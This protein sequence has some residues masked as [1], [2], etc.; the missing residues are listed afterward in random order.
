[1]ARQVSCVC[2]RRFHIG[3]SQA[4]VQCRQCGRWWSGTE[5]SPLG[6]VATLLFGGEIAGTKNKNGVRK[7]SRNYS[8]KTTQ[9]NR[10]RPASNPAGS[11]LRW[12]FGGG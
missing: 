3:H 4:N 12:F 2:G 1:M 6:A 5:L 9:T 7:T 11:V 10:K 8:H